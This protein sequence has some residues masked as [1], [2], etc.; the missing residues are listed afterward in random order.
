MQIQAIMDMVW[1]SSSR[2]RLCHVKTVLSPTHCI[3]GDGES[4]GNADNQKVLSSALENVIKFPPRRYFSTEIGAYSY[5]GGIIMCT[6]EFYLQLPSPPFTLDNVI[7]MKN[8]VTLLRA[9]TANNGGKI[10]P[11][12]IYW[13]IARRSGFKNWEALIAVAERNGINNTMQVCWGAGK[14]PIEVSDL[15]WQGL[16]KTI[17]GE[18]PCCLRKNLRKPGQTIRNPKG[19]LIVK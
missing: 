2:S 13:E 10:S 11:T 15:L 19:F 8:A 17:K 12:K 4:F 14:G 18:N 6:E 5:H 7:E 9:E 16:Q 1:N 3:S